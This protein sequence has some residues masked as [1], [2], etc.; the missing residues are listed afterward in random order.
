MKEKNPPRI[1]NSFLVAEVLLLDAVLKKCITNKDMAVLCRKP[2]FSSL[3]MKVT[4][5]AHKANHPVSVAPRGEE[6][7]V[8]IEE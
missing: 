4:K 8:T 2:A 7:I 1:A 6:R 3:L 5:M